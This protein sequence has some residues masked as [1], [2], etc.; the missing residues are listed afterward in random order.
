MQHPVPWAPKEMP[1]SFF[2]FFNLPL[3]W[4]CA[5]VILSCWALLSAP[6][7]GGSNTYSVRLLWVLNKTI[8]QI[9][10]SSPSHIAST[11][12]SCA[13]CFQFS[14]NDTYINTA[15]PPWSYFF[16]SICG[17]L[18]TRRS[19][20]RTDPSLAHSALLCLSEQALLCRYAR[21]R[22]YTPLYV[23]LGSPVYT[24]SFHP[25]ATPMPLVEGTGRQRLHFCCFW[26]HLIFLRWE[27]P[28]RGLKAPAL[29]WGPAEAMPCNSKSPALS[30]PMWGGRPLALGFTPWPR[31]QFPPGASSEMLVLKL[32]LK[33]PP[34][35]SF[36]DF[37]E[38]LPTQSP[39]E[40][41]CAQMSWSHHHLKQTLAQTS[42]QRSELHSTW[43]YK[44][45][46][47]Q[48]LKFPLCLLWSP[49]CPEL[50]SR[51]AQ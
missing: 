12:Y 46:G 23:Q 8:T 28:R 2:F 43:G 37:L 39:V 31:R 6:E 7:S 47:T 51:T 35:S 36:P 27:E 49:Q 10:Q 3:S 48:T 16:T 14:S 30:G 44:V 18:S 1:G 42:V 50:P 20:E 34:A 32:A 17:Y 11:P 9:S 15:C 21:W 38:I 13:P 26:K 25:T 41:L 5:Q 29:R 24:P 19:C 4:D 40:S 33:V 45:H 22:P